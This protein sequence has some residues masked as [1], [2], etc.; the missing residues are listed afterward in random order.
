M[1]NTLVLHSAPSKYWLT[2]ITR[3][4]CCRMFLSTCSFVLNLCN[5]VDGFVRFSNSCHA[6]HV[7]RFPVFESVLYGLLRSFYFHALFLVSYMNLLLFFERFLW[8]TIFW[9]THALCAI[10]IETKYSAFDFRRFMWHNAV[11]LFELCFWKPSRI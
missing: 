8:Q 10:H 7:S 3:F 4:S 9:T 2:F 11:H 6:C 1:T 5:S